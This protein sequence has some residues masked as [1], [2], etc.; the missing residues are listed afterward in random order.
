VAVQYESTA[1]N[2]VGCAR[3]DINGSRTSFV[4]AYVR[5]TMPTAYSEVIIQLSHSILSAH[6]FKLHSRINK[7]NIFTAKGANK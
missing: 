5:S 1:V 3:M 7:K 4:I 2:T 6:C